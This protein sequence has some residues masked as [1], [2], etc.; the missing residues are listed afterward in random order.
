M[1]KQNSVEAILLKGAAG[2]YCSKIFSPLKAC[3]V[4]LC[5]QTLELEYLKSR[6]FVPGLWIQWDIVFNQRVC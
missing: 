3:F 1:P 5:Y 4:I 2:Q 6:N